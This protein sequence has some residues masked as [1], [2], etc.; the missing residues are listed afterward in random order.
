MTASSRIQMHRCRECV[1]HCA[2]ITEAN[3][4]NR[5]WDSN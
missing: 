2:V 5:M 4:R 3:F 1:G